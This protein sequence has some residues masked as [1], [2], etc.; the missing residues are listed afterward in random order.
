MYLAS[1]SHLDEYEEYTQEGSKSVY[2]RRLLNQDNSSKRFALRTYIIKP[3]GH[4]SLDTHVHEH[5]VYIMK[6]SVRV[7]V[8]DTELNL[9]QG[10]VIHIGSN[11]PHQF[12]NDGSENVKFLCVRDYPT[13]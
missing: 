1:D 3:G 10:D 8:N 6:G 13:S 12:R 2:R 4:T 5:G 11:E 7:I 9:E